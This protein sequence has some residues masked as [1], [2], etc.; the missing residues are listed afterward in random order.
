[1]IK[2]AGGAGVTQIDGQNV[3]PL[4]AIILRMLNEVER[5]IKFEFG[6]TLLK[7]FRVSDI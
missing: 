4:W 5:K 6:R 2:A 1:M 7:E 3:D